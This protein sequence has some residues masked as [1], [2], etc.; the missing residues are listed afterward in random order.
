M[1]SY[2]FT[3]LSIIF[4]FFLQ[5]QLSPLISYSIQTTI[6]YFVHKRNFTAFAINS[7]FARTS[8]NSNQSSTFSLS[9]LHA[10]SQKVDGQNTYIWQCILFNNNIMYYIIGQRSNYRPLKVHLII[11]NYTAKHMNIKC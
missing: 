1:R 2:I 7:I 5:I 4:E 10:K 3:K 9:L 11:N 6:E 8:F